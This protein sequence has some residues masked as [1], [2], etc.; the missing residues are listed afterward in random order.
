MN[1]VPVK[2]QVCHD[3][4]TQTDLLHRL[5]QIALAKL[6]Q[7]LTAYE[8][9]RLGDELDTMRDGLQALL[10]MGANEIA[11]TERAIV[12]DTLTNATTA[13]IQLAARVDFINSASGGGNPPPGGSCQTKLPKLKLPTFKGDVLEWQ[14]FW[15]TFHA[16]VDSMQNLD[17]VIKFTYLK[18]CLEGEPKDLI[19]DLRLGAANYPNAVRM[20]RKRYEDEEKLRQAILNQFTYLPSIR[21]DYRDLKSFHTKLTRLQ[22]QIDEIPALHGIEEV[23]KT[24]AVQKLHDTTYTSIVKE[25]GRTKFSLSELIDKIFFLVD[26]CESN[27]LR[28][29]ETVQVKSTQQNVEGGARPK[30]P[31]SAETSRSNKF[32]C[33]FCNLDHRAFDC[34][35]YKTFNAR[36]DRVR[37]LKLCFNCLRKGHSQQECRNPARCRKCG[38]MHH[39]SLCYD[40]PPP[41][42][43]HTSNTTSNANNSNTSVAPPATT[44]TK[45]VVNKPVATPTTTNV[46]TIN[47]ASSVSLRPSATPTAKVILSRC[48]NQIATRIFID[49]GSQRSFISP[50]LVQ[51]LQLPVVAKIPMQIKTFGSEIIAETLDLVKVKVKLGLKR[52]T[53][54]LLVHEHAS[55]VIH[56]PGIHNVIET[57]KGSGVKLAD[58][59]IDCDVIRD[60]DVLIGIDYFSYFITGHRMINGVKMFVSSGGLIPY[61][62]LPKWAI[63]DSN[64]LTHGLQPTICSKVAC[65][66]DPNIERMWDLETVGI[67]KEYMSPNE[68]LTV[69]QG[70][71]TTKKTNEGYEVRLPFKSDERPPVNFRIAKGQLNSL[72]EKMKRNPL[73]FKQYDAVIQDYQSKGFIEHI[74]NDKIEGHYLPH[75]PVFKNSSTTP[76]RIVFN[77]SSKTPGN[78][79]LNDCLLTGPSLTAKLHDALV[80]FRTGKYA[81]ISDISKAFHRIRIDA[82]DQAYVKFLWTNAECTSQL[83]FAF[84]VVIF[85]ATCSPFLLQQVLL[86]HLTNHVDGKPFVSK[87]YVDNYQNNYDDEDKLIQDKLVL[88]RIMNEAHMPLQA[89]ASNSVEFNRVFAIEAESI[90]NVLGLRW[91]IR[92]DKLH[93]AR[94]DKIPTDLT[95]WQPTKRL[96]LSAL[97]SV[98]DP[99]GLLNPVLIKSKIFMQTLWR[100]NVSWDQQLNPIL[101]NEAKTL[102]HELQFV[103]NIAFPRRAINREQALHVFVDASSR[104]YGTV[105]YT[106]CQE[107]TN[108]VLSKARV[109]P[110]RENSV[111]IPKLEL[112]AMLLGCRTISY[113]SSFI[114]ANQVYLWSDSKVALAWVSS[115]KEMKN[116]FV[117]NRVNEIKLLQNKF[118]INLLHVSSEENVADLLTRGCNIN[119]LRNSKWMA[120]PTWLTS[121][122]DFPKQEHEITLVSEIVVEI[123]PVPPVCPLI[124]LSR[125]SKFIYALRTVCRVLQFCK[126][127]LDPFETLVKQE[128]KLHSN[129]LYTYLRD[130]NTP[131]SQDIKQTVKQLSLCIRN[132]I[133]RCAGRFTSSELPLDAQTPY[134]I[135]NRSRLVILFALH[136]HFIY[137]HASVSFVL[138]QYRLIAWTPKLR[139]RLKVAL[140]E[141]YVCRRMRKKA[142]S[143]P[144]P[145][146]L[147]E[148][149]SRWHTPFEAVGVDH[150]GHFHI[151]QDDGERTKAYICLF[152]CTVTRAVHLEVVTSLT[153]TSFLM[154]LRRLA[155]THG[156]PKL[157]LSDNHRTFLAT[158]RFL[159]D[160]Q[161]D[162]EI[163]DFVA[164]RRIQWRSQ[165]PRAPW[166]GGHFERLVRTVKVALA[167]AISKKLLTLEEFT[168]VVKESETIVNNRPLTYQQTDSQDIPLTPSQL[169]RGRN[170]EL[171]PTVINPGVDEI[172]T[173]RLRH[174]YVRISNVLQTF[175]RRWRDE[176]LTSLRE[177]HQNVCANQ[178]AYELKPGELVLLKIAELPRDQWPLG[179]IMTVFKDTVG[180]IRSTEV[181][182]GGERYRRPIEH[183]IPLELSSEEADN[184]DD[185]DGRIPFSLPSDERSETED[186]GDATSNQTTA[187]ESPTR[188][189]LGDDV[190]HDVTTT[191]RGES[192]TLSCDA[193]DQ[194]QGELGLPSIDDVIRDASHDAANHHT[195][196]QP[197]GR[198]YS[199]STTA[200]PRPHPQ[201]RPKRNAATRQRELMSS[202]IQQDL[203]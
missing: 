94:G 155:A 179:K 200:A 8:F 99:L 2:S 116:V 23:I 85:G 133:I 3:I 197:H 60:V 105:V 123:N 9:Q 178:N 103:D 15:S 104:A 110:C 118:N 50:K 187:E 167:T 43:H 162:P 141:C 32:N 89:W 107:S 102:M 117:A 182:V 203:V 17:P 96:F 136:L 147:P 153:A 26:I 16:H 53:M 49:S 44:L 174:Q 59:S 143:R 25:L 63:S 77:A 188:T 184:D 64:S 7:T 69:N 75:H 81:V 55:T 54:K 158:E 98:F 111:T 180:V 14:E 134:F 100:E 22:T 151:R 70:K 33:Q 57:L 173:N 48:D 126:S 131:V 10:S 125:F 12:A 76:L 114:T 183:I 74:P 97:S 21:H 108:L 119:T 80:Q 66:I 28:R 65:E 198:S 175:Q 191:T 115:T 150:T 154:C 190:T 46:T 68:T 62:L 82:R 139:S 51:Q 37:T 31:T 142:L 165:T 120:G 61:G 6:S 35:K 127:N 19:R 124:D 144:P 5:T 39:T 152:V 168:T 170:V 40:K 58:D 92:S 172:D 148:V 52:I 87:F 169:I 181:C 138:S 130:K 156:I 29:N 202:L 157:I 72:Q 1:T 129:S 101:A 34:M 78:K 122:L 47:T 86:T 90:Q 137:N 88:D 177:K 20:L 128:Q 36:R 149:R 201:P 84:K 56:C 112:T 140:N 135:P 121:P 145:P 13:I 199:T 38:S 160:L 166:S 132:N 186:D 95:N 109:A 176:Y 18:G 146:P 83:T 159:H 67:N 73:L 4:D 93:V 163:Q 27:Q 45:P 11:D 79:S 71:A 194:S 41:P 196:S 106:V 195:D 42:V 164:A 24:I 185:P 193:S 189:T 30:Q 171:F 192:S 161:H 91:D 113:L